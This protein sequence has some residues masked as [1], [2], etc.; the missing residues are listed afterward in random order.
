MWLV[1]TMWPGSGACMVGWPL[2]RPGQPASP[3]LSFPP[4]GGHLAVDTTGS[5]TRYPTTLFT[6]IEGQFAGI[7]N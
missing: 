7:T 3:T 6:S 4:A 2:T 1:C 5:S